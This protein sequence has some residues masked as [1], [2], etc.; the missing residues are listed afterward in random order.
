MDR[1][2]ETVQTIYAAFGRGDVPA[3]LEHLAPDIEWEHDAIDHGVPFLRPRRG[4]AE[5]A[6]FFGDLAAGLD[7]AVFEPLGFLVGGDQVAVPVRLEGTLRRNGRRVKD[8][9]I[10]LWTFDANGH[11]ARFRHV[12]DTHQY[13]AP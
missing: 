5:V 4:R 7:I 1:R 6:G 12:L 10:H 8:H 3:I 9:E 13:A 11:V 2:V